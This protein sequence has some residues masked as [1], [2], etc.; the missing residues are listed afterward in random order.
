MRFGELL[1]TAIKHFG[2]RERRAWMGRNR[3]HIEFKH[4]GAAEY[5]LFEAAV[6]E[7]AKELAQ[8]LW[9]EVNPY[10]ERVVFAFEDGAYSEHRLKELVASA[11]RSAGLGSAKFQDRDADHP[12]DVEPTERLTLELAADMVG[13]AVGLGLKFTPLPP[14]MVASGTASILA[15]VRAT[16]RLRRS[17]DERFGFDR[18]DLALGITGGLTLGFAQRPLSS[19]VE[20]F[21]KAALYREERGRRQVWEQREP[22]LCGAP[23]TYDPALLATEPRPRPMPPGP[24]EEYADKAWMV[25]LGGFA[26]SFL[27][28]RSVP[29]ATAALF[30]GLPKPARLGRDV[31]ATGFSQTLAKRGVLVKNRHILRRLD[32]VDCLVLQGD[33]VARDRFVVGEIITESEGLNENEVRA[34]VNSLFDAE[35]AIEVQRADAWSL[36]PPPLVRASLSP[37]L[38]E[39]HRRMSAQGGLVL[40][41]AHGV[42]AVALVEVRVI[43]QTGIDELIAAAH[44]A[45]MRVVIASSDEEVLQGLP[46]DDTIGEGEG[47]RLG[48][49]RLQREGRVVCVVGTGNSPGLAVADVAIGLTRHTL[50]PTP[51]AAHILCSDD[52]TDVRF[53][54]HACVI[55]RQI[56]KQSVNVALGA[57][58]VG[59]LVSAGGLLPLTGRRVLTVVNAASMIAMLNGV[60]GS[61]TLAR[62]ALPPPRDRTP[63]HALD[64]R[65]VLTQLTTAETG[66]SHREASER[67]RPEATPRTRFSGLSEAITDELFNPLAPLLAA[68]AGLSAVVGSFGDA[69]MVG[70]VV[71]VNAV[72]G[73][74]QKFRTER[75][76]YDLAQS[77][78]RR[79]SVLRA[80][81]VLE[82]DAAQ[83]V[84]GDILLLGPGDAVPADCRILE[85]ESLEVDASGLT[86]ESLP[87][88]KS[89]APSFEANV[90]DR[91]SML[92]E[93]TNIASGRAKAIV[94]AVGDVTEAR[95][96]AVAPRHDASRSGVER[97][98]KSLIDL[99][100]PI[101]LGAGAGLIGVGLLRGRKLEDLVGSAV[102]LAVASV[103]EGLPVLATAAQLAAA[104]RLSKRGALVRN[105]RS[106]EALGRVDVLCLDKTGTLTEGRIELSLVADLSGEHELSE[107]GYARGFAILGAA[108]RA[109]PDPQH[110]VS[111]GDPTDASLF[112]AAA[113]FA[114]RAEHGREAWQRLAELSFE[115]G[116]GYHAVLGESAI[117]ALLSVKG[118]PEILIPRSTYVEVDGQI[119]PLEEE[120]RTQLDEIATRMARRGLRV[121]AVGEKLATPHALVEPS[122]VND[123]VFQGF[124]A[125]RDPVR[126]TSAAAIERLRRAGV[127]P[128]MITG[129][130]PSTAEAIARELGLL[131]GDRVMSGAELSRLSD[132]E[133]DAKVDHIAVFARVTPP[134]KVRVVRALQRASHVVAMVG[135][136]AN[137]APAIRL[138]NVGIAIGEQST[139]AARAAADIVLTDERIETLVDAIAEGRAMWASVRDAVSILVGGN[140][141]EIAFTLLGGLV[142]GR[143]PLN[144]R[145]LLLVNL[146]TDVAPA[147]AIAL[148]PPDAATLSSLANEGPDASL[149][150]PLNRD[151]AARATITAIGAGTAWMA[152]RFTSSRPRASTVGL[153]ALV[154]TQLGQTLVSGRFNRSVVTTSLASAGVLAAIVQTPGVSGIFGCRPI[155]PIGW[156]LAVGSSAG[157]TALGAYFPQLSNEAIKWWRLNR[158]MSLADDP[159]VSQPEPHGLR[160][161]IA[162]IAGELGASSAEG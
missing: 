119:V 144:P 48:I 99:T 109:A 73:G 134:Q 6:R 103:P 12:A 91:T 72:V 157:A 3:A 16:P 87:V 80:G 4:V 17:L 89:A 84:R 94:V 85:S 112:R 55:A 50:E 155:G 71:V 49:R 20:L 62:Q 28:T 63:W 159:D 41:L 83:L 114:V 27:T 81:E 14:S 130:H 97:R 11:E 133:L 121:L 101:A 153:L 43:T 30:G 31:F 141:G 24:I 66:L 53:I 116:R 111:Q 105:A 47:M 79:A 115:S 45:Q 23:I 25:G 10:T 46:A 120:T 70:G 82:V 154:G 36:G 33:L 160:H 67:T 44:A 92:F 98:L 1:A 40:A 9:V 56:S 96:G 57:A 93:G 77:S 107:D 161:S 8:L 74:V 136:G 127:R 140:L 7:R 26:V 148:R 38:G 2:E 156:A 95:R 15:V 32:R 131:R 113:H 64:A 142:D 69:A 39:Q 125:F 42:V 22:E 147:M 5:P 13:L 90:A 35:H 110:H 152:S 146:L 65:G 145:Q 135:D 60:R 88:K 78:R 162:A 132:E 139:S 86:G 68:G 76:I 54:I 149:G 51:W 158:R 29:R 123:L 117:G 18:S 129:D 150:Q 19:A 151:I 104:E 37:K 75:A 59:A 106:I 100:G 128:V 21:H 122:Q 52:L 34:R 61:A 124:I 102:S 118:A 143:P 138:A 126:P 108:L 58:T 137:D